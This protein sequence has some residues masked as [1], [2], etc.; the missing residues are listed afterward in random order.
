MQAQIQGQ[1]L[2]VGACGLW[3]AARARLRDNDCVCR[4]PSEHND[5]T[6]FARRRCAGRFRLARNDNTYT[7]ARHT[8]K[9]LVQIAVL[10]VYYLTVLVSPS[11]IV[12]GLLYIA[13]TCSQVGG[14]FVLDW[15]HAGA[16]VSQAGRM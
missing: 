16:S 7:D 1:I 9:H 14:G 3:L 10:P 15:R 8:E 13:A 6:A 2:F 5:L 11:L 4:P 12:T